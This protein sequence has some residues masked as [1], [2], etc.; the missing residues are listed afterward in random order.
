MDQQVAFDNIIPGKE[1]QVIANSMDA[2]LQSDYSKSEILPK[3]LPFLGKNLLEERILEYSMEP[4]VDISNSYFVLYEPFVRAKSALLIGTVLEKCTE[5]P[6]L[7]SYVDPLIEMVKGEEDIEQVFAFFAL[8]CIGTHSPELVLEKLNVLAPLIITLVS[9][10]TKPKNYFSLFHMSAF[11]YQVYDS[12]L[13]FLHIP[14]LLDTPDYVTRFVDA[15]V[16]F[17]VFQVAL[18]THFYLPKHPNILF[19]ATNVFLRLATE[20]PMG[21]KMWDLDHI[22]KDETLEACALMRI[23]LTGGKDKAVQI[24]NEFAKI[25]KKDYTQE[26]FT[27]FVKQYK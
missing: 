21:I 19:K 12:F 11:V 22:P 15:N 8:A 14:K 7:K 9:N 17:A 2:L 1:A 4:G 3:L 24:R 20:H 25:D 23:A 26:R 13:D 27:S 6:D 16:T 5:A 10:A 18:S